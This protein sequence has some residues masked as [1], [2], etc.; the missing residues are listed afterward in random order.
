M[1]KVVTLKQIRSLAKK[2]ALVDS[3]RES[4]M[5]ERDELMRRAKGE[6]A[7]W[8]ELQDAAGMNSPTAVS[9]ALKRKA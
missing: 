8:D 9:R 4:L 5:S 7:T 1:E 2:I 6:G 3:R